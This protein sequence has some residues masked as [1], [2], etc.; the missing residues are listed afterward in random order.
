MS[1]HVSFPI[2]E[3]T[4]LAVVLFAC[5]LVVVPGFDD[6][7][8]SMLFSSDSFSGRGPSALASKPT[9]HSAEPSSLN[10]RFTNRAAS[11][12]G[13]F[14]KADPQANF[15]TALELVTV[16]DSQ[17][18]DTLSSNENELFSENERL[19]LPPSNEIAIRDLAPLE[20]DEQNRFDEFGDEDAFETSPKMD[21]DQ[22]DRDADGENF[23]LT[24]PLEVPF[25]ENFDEMLVDQFD[26]LDQID[27]P[28]LAESGPV[29]SGKSSGPD[30]SGETDFQ[31]SAAD[32][33]NTDS[34][35][36]GES[37]VEDNSQSGMLIQDDHGSLP[38]I[39]NQIGNQMQVQNGPTIIRMPK[40]F[41]SDVRVV[42]NPMY[43]KSTGVPTG[44]P[45]ENDAGINTSPTMIP[46]EIHALEP[47]KSGPNRP[48]QIRTTAKPSSPSAND[49]YFVPQR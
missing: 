48:Y 42:V 24:P 2:L 11:E 43:V 13:D 1:K 27:S 31:D 45:S 36:L 21:L 7:T 40:V 8:T 37:S 4:T 47:P 28:S 29:E 26:K 18:S 20:I 22:E 10:R 41:P 6:F 38:R 16:P 17:S 3:I 5:I 39:L 19:Q 23:D 33:S 14:A 32:M 34:L 12:A 9:P 35:T 44:I 15:D 49:N 30:W 25:P 46:G